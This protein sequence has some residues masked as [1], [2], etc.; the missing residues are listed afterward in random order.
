[1]DLYKVIADIATLFYE[2]IVGVESMTLDVTATDGSAERL[3]GEFMLVAAGIS[4]HRFYGGGKAVLPGADNLC[5]ISRLGLI[6]K[7]RL[8]SLF[9]RGDHVHEPNVS[10]RS[11]AALCVEYGR[12]IPMQVDGETAWLE[13]AN[14]PLRI[15]RVIDSIPVLSRA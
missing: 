14:F 6:G 8:K 10:M 12:R 2:Q 15:E 7:I 5:A 13:P 3:T 11:F 9:Y 4:G 1:G